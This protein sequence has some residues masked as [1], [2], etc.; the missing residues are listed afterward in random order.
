VRPATIAAAVLACAA[1]AMAVLAFTA[2]DGGEEERAAVATATPAPEPAA[3]RDGMAVW[4]ANGCGS[5]H[6]FAPA[7]A[8]GQFGP[9]LSATLKGMPASYIRESIVNPNAVAAAGFS[10]GAMP[11]DFGAR[12]AP[13]ELDALVEFIRSGVRN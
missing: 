2:G 10:T 11:E 3:V 9:N 13:A 4:V 8:E 5:C 1:A 7:N 6:T 12:I